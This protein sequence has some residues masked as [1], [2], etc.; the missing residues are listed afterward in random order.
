MNNEITNTLRTI[1]SSGR[2]FLIRVVCEGDRYGMNDK[3]EHDEPDPLI[4][5]YDL[6]D[7]PIE[8]CAKFGPR[9]QF[10]SRYYLS[11]LREDQNDDR[12]LC[13]DGGIPVWT[14]NAYIVNQAIALGDLLSK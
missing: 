1:N 5:F 6:G 10:V 11:D 3:I 14:V 12:D 7:S 13:L 9:G 2:S 8:T 4:E